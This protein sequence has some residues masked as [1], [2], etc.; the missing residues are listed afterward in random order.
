M[1]PVTPLE[2]SKP[3]LEVCLE[4]SDGPV[5][6]WSLLIS[7]IGSMHESPLCRSDRLHAQLIKLV[8]C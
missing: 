3:S 4:D 7:G 1:E 2:R 5:A 8:N 6:G